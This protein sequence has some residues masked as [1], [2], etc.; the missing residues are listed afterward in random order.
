MHKTVIIGDLH[1]RSDWKLIVH[2]NPDFTKLV[3]LGDYFDSFDIK[4]E[5]QVNNFL[6][7]IAYKES[8]KKEGKEVILLWGNHDETYVLGNSGTS[9]FQ[10]I[11]QFLITPVLNANKNSL[12]IAYQQDNILFSH[13]GISESF[14]NWAVGK[15]EWNIDNIPEKLNELWKY[16]PLSFKFGV[17]CKTYCDPYGDDIEQ[18]PLWIRPR[19]L[20]KDAKNLKKHFIQ[21]CGHTQQTNIDILGKSTGGRYYFVDT[22]P[23]S[24]EYLII[25]DGK[26]IMKSLKNDMQKSTT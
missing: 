18:S 20:M 19:S 4:T 14:L 16:K 15:N 25:E 22:L 13:A 26:I 2:L 17:G 1:G 6:D 24:G 5:D 21:I 11:G 23:T 12:Q 10:E 7:I 3:Y 9:G 8:M